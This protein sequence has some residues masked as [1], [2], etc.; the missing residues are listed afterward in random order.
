M[1]DQELTQADQNLEET[2]KDYLDAFDAR[3]LSRCVGFYADDA[4]IHFMS[5][6][7]NARPAIEEWHRD[8]FA[9]NARILS[10]DG[11]QVSG[12][13]VAVDIVMTSDRF[14]AWKVDSI[15]ARMNYEFQN[16]KITEARYGLR[17]TS[18]EIW[19][20]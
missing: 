1:A 10:V 20:L 15:S 5:G 8:R 17:A 13:K 4:V 9:A 16:G 3:D 19:R 14:Q 7:Y 2:I 11:I 6:I 12:D 18:S